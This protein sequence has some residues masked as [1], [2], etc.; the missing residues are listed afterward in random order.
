MIA[1]PETERVTPMTY[2]ARAYNSKPLSPARPQNQA[3]TRAA[4][5]HSPPP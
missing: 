5:R 4:G 3:T 2:T 1:L